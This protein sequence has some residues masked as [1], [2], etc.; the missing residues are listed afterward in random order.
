MNPDIIKSYLVKLGVQVDSAA[1]NKMQS[2]LDDVGKAI[3]GNAV[4]SSAAMLK[5]ASTIVG[6]LVAIDTAIIKTVEQ[7]AKADLQYQL[8]AQRM[9]LSVDA[10]KAFKLSSDALGASIHEIAWNAELKERY[11]ILVNQINELKT[12]PEARRMLQEVRS[13]GFEFTKLKTS[14]TSAIEWI[15]FHL[16][17]LNKGELFE[18]RSKLTEWVD[19]IIKNIPEWSKKVAD[20]L[21]VPLQLL[22]SALKFLEGIWT[23]GT[24]L[25]GFILD[26]LGKIWRLLPDIGKEAALLG[27]ILAPLFFLNSPFLLGLAAISTALLLIDDLMAFKEGRESLKLLVPVWETLEIAIS[28]VVAAI[29]AADVAYS[30]FVAYREGVPHPSGLSVG[31]DIK[32]SIQE[33][34]DDVDRSIAERR[35]SAGVKEAQRRSGWQGAFIQTIKEGEGTTLQDAEKAGYTS[36]YDMPFGG[37]KYAVPEKPLSSMT[38]DEVQAFQKEL[39]NAQIKQG[40]APK[41]ASGAVGFAQFTQGTLNMLK[42]QLNLSGDVKFTSELQEMLALKL[43]EKEVGEFQSGKR[44]A[45]SLHGKFADTWASFAKYGTNESTYGQSVGVS[46]EEIQSLIGLIGKSKEAKTLRPASAYSKEE[47]QGIGGFYSG[48][49]PFDIKDPEAIKKMGPIMRVEPN[50]EWLWNDLNRTSAK[51]IDWIWNGMR[52]P[53]NLMPAAVNAAGDSNIFHMNVSFTNKEITPEEA[54]RMID[55]FRR[56]SVRDVEKNKAKM[57]AKSKIR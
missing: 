48:K 18:M 13:I 47:L 23:V 56:I 44:S 24:K 10:A 36:E 4:T 41:D 42:K 1:F 29:I 31:E 34:F 52:A 21:Q 28:K 46:S 26:L 14:A 7:V 22:A 17:K 2:I 30:H 9:F 40:V 20:F 15:T 43:V 37:S 39:I 45:A 38:L 55:E 57:N 19:K 25:G 51:I 5:G 8:L 53:F 49:V 32:K 27:A 11:F 35:L 50:K 3:S 12:P 33:H 54:A 6:A 16:L